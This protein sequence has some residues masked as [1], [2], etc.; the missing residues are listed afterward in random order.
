[1]AM[2][3][4]KFKRPVRPWQLVLISKGF[5]GSRVKFHISDIRRESSLID[6]ILRKEWVDL[7]PL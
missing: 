1:M 7:R 2:L 4:M 6:G 5:E 3:K